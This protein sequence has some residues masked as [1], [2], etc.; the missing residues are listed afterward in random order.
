[1]G[2]DM[3]L[4]KKKKNKPFELE[5]VGRWRKAN[6]I[7]YWF[8]KN[9]YT[10][11]NGG[12]YM[13]KKEHLE[14]L[15]DTCIK[16]LESCELVDGKKIVGKYVKYV[17]GE[18]IAIVVNE[19][20]D[21]KLNINKYHILKGFEYNPLEMDCKV[22]KDYKY[23]EENLPTLKG[24]MYGR[25]DYTIE[26]YSDIVDTI[27]MLEKLLSEINFESNFIYYHYSF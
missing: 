23:A 14:K 6:Q 4:Y 26:Y 5:E 21:S 1:M 12:Y 20:I 3:Y 22:I 25:T 15:L 8:V 7:H 24:L 10:N 17:N 9:L 18:E 13:V 2:L 11:K 19:G 27:S 16:V